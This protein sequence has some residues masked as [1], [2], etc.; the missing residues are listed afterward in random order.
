MG[1]TVD[2]MAEF[3]DTPVKTVN[4]IYRQ[5]DDF[6]RHLEV[7]ERAALGYPSKPDEQPVPSQADLLRQCPS[8]PSIQAIQA[9]H[10]QERRLAPCVYHLYAEQVLGGVSTLPDPVS[11][12]AE[13]DP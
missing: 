9:R 1:F 11:G 10:G 2:Q 4:R 13:R 8:S 6:G 3:T 12:G 5:A 7:P